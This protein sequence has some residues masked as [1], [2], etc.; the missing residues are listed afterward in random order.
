MAKKRPFVADQLLLFFD[1]PVA[2]PP[3]PAADAESNEPTAD[4]PALCITC[5]SSRPQCNK[6]CNTCDDICSQQQY[7]L[8]EET[9]EDKRQ[10]EWE[11]NERREAICKTWKECE[12][13]EICF[14]PQNEEDGICF[15]DEPHRIPVEH[16]PIFSRD[17][18]KVLASGFNLV[19]YTRDEKKIEMSEAD[20]CN[21]WLLL[22]PFPTFAAAE[23]KLKELKE[24]GDIE[25]GID[26][27]IIMSGWNQPGGLLKAGF[28]F[29]RCCGLHSYD[30]SFCIKV[31]SKNWSNL[32]KYP[33]AAALRTAWSELM[34]NSKALEG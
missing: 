20:P 8:I 15:F 24:R 27:K 13:K 6:C 30:T 23:R 34:N 5:R 26:G 17:Q 19:R 16:R 33:D 25:T 22:E 2:S 29:Y 21:G 31:G 32:A 9:E 7:C 3:D 11:E 4:L 12:H 1:E 18:L 28:E 10:E 14:T